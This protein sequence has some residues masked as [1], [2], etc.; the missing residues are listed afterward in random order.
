MDCT[1]LAN[2]CAGY[3]NRTVERTRP[4]LGRTDGCPSPVGSPAG[5]HGRYD[6]G[7]HASS[8]QL[9]HN[10]RSAALRVRR[11]GHDKQP[12]QSKTHAFHDPHHDRFWFD[13]Y[14]AQWLSVC[15]ASI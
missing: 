3:T 8:L 15:P 7:G 11:A 6:L 10:L 1:E 14:D 12:K 2:T 9:L 5:T 13:L 4:D